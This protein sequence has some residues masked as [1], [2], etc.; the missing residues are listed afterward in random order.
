MVVMQ[1][2]QKVSKMGITIPQKALVKAINNYCVYIIHATY[3]T[4]F[5]ALSSDLKL[6]GLSSN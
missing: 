6:S 5:R 1:Q 4:Q 3:Q 2:Q